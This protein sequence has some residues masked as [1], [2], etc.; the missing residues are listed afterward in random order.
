[1]KPDL[2][3]R[4]EDATLVLHVLSREP[5]SRTLLEQRCLGKLSHACFDAAFFWLKFDGD[6]EKCTAESRAPFRVTVKGEAFLAWRVIDGA[7]NQ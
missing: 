4:L 6:I 3:R 1:M 2:L 7:Q 5:L